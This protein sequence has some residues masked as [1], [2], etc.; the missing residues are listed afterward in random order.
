MGIFDSLF[1]KKEI[2]LDKISSSVL[3]TVTIAESMVVM[4]ETL[5]SVKIKR[6]FR[7][8]QILLLYLDGIVDLYNTAFDVKKIIKSDDLIK[9]HH[10][11]M[12]TFCVIQHHMQKIQDR[13]KKVS[14]FKTEELEKLKKKNKK[15][16]KKKLDFLKN[17]YVRSI[18]DR[19]YEFAKFFYLNKGEIVGTK[20]AFDLAKILADQEIQF[21][22]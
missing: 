2:D 20:Y 19:G 8:D 14:E 13:D 9:K 22:K 3:G 17:E 15:E 6:D 11:E 4:H 16:L 7:Y 1:P 18:S 12:R 10:E 5:K 21:E